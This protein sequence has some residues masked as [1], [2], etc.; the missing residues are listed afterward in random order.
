VATLP[1][2]AVKRYAIYK[3]GIGYIFKTRTETCIKGEVELAVF[4]VF[5]ECRLG[6]RDLGLLLAVVGFDLRLGVPSSVYSVGHSTHTS[7]QAILAH[8]F[9]AELEEGEVGGGGVYI[10][11]RKGVGSAGVR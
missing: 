7:K 6:V 11:P 8:T 3:T 4:E 2:F 10:G 5:G 9:P 1:C